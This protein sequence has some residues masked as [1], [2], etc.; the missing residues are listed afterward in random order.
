[1]TVEP[2]KIP[3][4]DGQSVSAVVAYHSFNVPTSMQREPAAV[5]EE[6]ITVSANWLARL[7]G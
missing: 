1:M 6:M 2:R 5:L 7:P 3:L 4:S